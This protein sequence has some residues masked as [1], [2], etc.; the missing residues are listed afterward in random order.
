MEQRTTRS[1]TTRSTT[2]AL[3]DTLPTSNNTGQPTTRTPN[4]GHP[5]PRGTTPIRPAE[6]R[7]IR[8][9]PRARGATLD[10]EEGERV[11]SEGEWPPPRPRSHDRAGREPSAPQPLPTPPDAT[12]APCVGVGRPSRST[13][14]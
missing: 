7:W 1:T 12:A 8:W 5:R 13:G 10:G 2:T 4:R 3:P 11:H 6:R 9:P 14:R